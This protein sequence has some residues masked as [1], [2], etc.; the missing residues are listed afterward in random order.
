MES[1]TVGELFAGA[2]GNAGDPRRTLL[3]AGLQAAGRA[4]SEAWRVLRLPPCEHA[5]DL[6]FWLDLLE[7][8]SGGRLRT[9]MVLWNEPVPG[10]PSRPILVR[11]RIEPQDFRLFLSPGVEEPRILDPMPPLRPAPDAV[12]AANS[13]LGTSIENHSLPLRD[14]AAALTGRA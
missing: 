3:V 11:D 1:R 12:K 10:C 7:R 8:F 2:L 9:R 4:G 5:G 14:L 6:G 13:R